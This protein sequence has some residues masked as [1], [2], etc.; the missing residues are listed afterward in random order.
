MTVMAINHRQVLLN[1][2]LNPM[3]TR[4]KTLL[5]LVLGLAAMRSSGTV[6]TYSTPASW[7]LAV[8]SP[9][10]VSFE[11]IVPAG[12]FIHYPTP[13]GVNVAGVQFDIPE[14]PNSTPGFLWILGDGYYAPNAVLSSQ[15]STVSSA[16]TVTFP[17]PVTAAAFSIWGFGQNNSTGATT[18]DFSL[19]SGGTVSTT[20][21]GF[22]SP[23]T[24]IGLV[25]TTPFST[26]TIVSDPS[27][28]DMINLNS[29]QF[30]SVPGAGCLVN[31]VP[32]FYQ[33]PPIDPS[34]L[35]PLTQAQLGDAP[36]ACD[37]YA[38]SGVPIRTLGCLLTA[39]AMSLKFAGVTT[40]P[41]TGQAMDPGS[42]N[43]YLIRQSLYD[44]EYNLSAAPLDAAA[45]CISGYRLKLNYQS[46]F[47]P[48]S[49]EALEEMLCKGFP[50]IVE[51]TPVPHQHFVLVT[52]Y[53]GDT[54]NIIDP[55]R[56]ANT[57]LA[58]YGNTFVEIRGYI[59]DPPEDIS[60]LDM[61]VGNNAELL[62]VDP[63]GN[64]TGFD[65][66]TGSI[67]NDIPHSGHFVDQV[68]D[69]DTGTTRFG[70]SHSVL[71]FQPTPGTYL[72]RLTGL[73]S[74]PYSISTYAF[75]QDGS[76]E[77]PVTINGVVSA[78]GL[79][80]FQ[81]NVLTTSGSQTILTQILPPL[82]SA[83]G[84]YTAE[85]S[86]ALTTVQLDGSASG[87]PSGSA[88]TF[89]WTSDCPGAV[90]DNPASPA[91]TLILDSTQVPET[92]T[93]TLT[94]VD[95][96]GLSS[97]CSSTVSVID[98]TPPNLTCPS[99]LVVEFIDEKGAPASFTATATDVCSPV[100]IAFTPPSGSLFPIGG[101]PV[102]VEAT[103]A[104]GNATQCTF[105]VT[106]LGA[107]GVKSNV[108]AQ[109]VNLRATSTTG[110][111]CWELDE[112]IEDM[113]DALGL[114][115]PQAPA[116]VRNAH[117]TQNCPRH[118]HHPRIPLWLD[119]THVNPDAA[120]WV[121]STEKDTV[122]ELLQ[123]ITAKKST[124]PDTTAQNLTDILA[125]IVSG[126]R[127]QIA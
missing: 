60:A 3:H 110:I 70:I 8:S 123:I 15:W 98:T 7:N 55:G 87:D 21:G 37:N 90:F 45:R 25:S 41:D 86:G 96:F 2:K 18:Y 19:D 85:C 59:A 9:V 67:L 10:S 22:W 120:W 81:A 17:T 72:L 125:L 103:D 94:V 68:T 56:R 114:D 50:V 97:T 91:P 12:S 113:I 57:T 28:P 63:A 61:D 29:V 40:I 32:I 64:R 92:C 126:K 95:S 127:S 35:C 1:D 93:V 80:V 65:G 34:I 100:T 47:T 107:R 14:P 74:G 58:A 42:L 77:V 52:G 49:K 102:L 44:T 78:G 11:G 99:T 124:I 89:S 121:F 53:Q 88:L 79:Q 82:C 23:A 66:S 105:D 43:Q 48:T 16:L 75:A 104:S 106:V 73:N 39:F 38:N 5:F 122:R 112:A 26:V 116:W 71:I 51:V 46:Q 13:P 4:I 20:Q 111:D 76:P 118:H 108:L 117:R 36:W 115:V 101:T 24:F 62:I 69:N 83:G 33:A 31:N 30:K 119:E 6:F 84:P 27:T 109:L 54:F